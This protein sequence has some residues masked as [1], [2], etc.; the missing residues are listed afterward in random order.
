MR[1]VLLC[2]PKFSHYQSIPRFA[3]L[4]LEALSARGINV[5]AWYPESRVFHWVHAPR[6]AKWLGYLVQYVEFPLRIRWRLRAL[7]ADTLFVFCDQALGPWIPIV[8]RRPHVVHVHDLLALR[9]ALGDFPRH[10]TAFTGRLL[11][12]YIRRGFRMARHFISISHRTRADLH[13]FGAVHP[14]ISEVVY[15]GLAFPFAPLRPGLACEVLA[16]SGL[17]IEPDGML[18]YVGGD[19]WYKNIA[20]LI[21]LYAH[22]AA[23]FETPLPLWCISPKP[24]A[25]MASLIAAKVPKRGAI[26]FFQSLPDRTLQAAYSRAQALVFPSLAEGFGWPLIEAQACGCPVLTINDSPMNEVAGPA[27]WYVDKVSSYSDLDSWAAQ[28]A[29]VLIE[30]LSTER[31]RLVERRQAGLAWASQFTR[32]RAVSGYLE[33]YQRVW[34][35]YSEDLRV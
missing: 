9:S 13:D 8:C 6:L 12:R 34:R 20:G 35:S 25:D 4:L 18:L 30:L 21:R 29:D 1:V 33:I 28:A 10:R 5:Q 24:S 7:P 16:Q 15:N 3:Q 26:K 31:V 2:H 17:P 14:R 19:Q 11:Q 32:E 23:R 27:A 22:Y